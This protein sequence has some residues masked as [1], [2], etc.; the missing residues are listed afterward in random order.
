MNT[1]KNVKGARI[2]A[3]VLWKYNKATGMW[4]HER[5]SELEIHA[6]LWKGIFE[7]H[8]PEGIYRISK[9]RPTIMG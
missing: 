1:Q 7:K 8:D 4:N 5:D 2:K 9:T 3:F 6:I